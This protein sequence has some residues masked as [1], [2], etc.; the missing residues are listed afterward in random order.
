MAADFD[1]FLTDGTGPEVSV[2]VFPAPLVFS[3]CWVRVG[4]SCF[5]TVWWLRVEDI[6]VR[7]RE[8]VVAAGCMQ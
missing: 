6:Q 7:S 5:V 8:L 3:S 1:V 2:H 4:R